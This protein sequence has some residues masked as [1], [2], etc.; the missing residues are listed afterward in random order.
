MFKL[1]NTNIPELLC[2]WC[3]QMLDNKPEVQ[4]TAVEL[5]PNIFH[6]CLERGDPQITVGHLEEIMDNLFKVLD[7]PKCSRNHPAAKDAIAKIVD[8]VIAMKDPGM[9]CAK[10]HLFVYN[11]GQ[12]WQ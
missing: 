2:G 11:L 3:T 5:M 9:I 4:K 6:K 8:D 10:S 7:D 12:N 1:A